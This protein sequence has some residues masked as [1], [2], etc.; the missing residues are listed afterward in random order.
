MPA[1]FQVLP[2]SK[3]IWILWYN[4]NFYSTTLALIPFHQHCILHWKAKEDLLLSRLQGL[5]HLLMY[6]YVT[7]QS[8]AT[9]ACHIFYESDHVVVA[10]CRHNVVYLQIMFDKTADIYVICWCSGEITHT[11]VRSVDKNNTTYPMS[12][13]R[14][15]AWQWIGAKC[16]SSIVDAKC[17]F[18]GLP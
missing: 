1:N 16:G 12:I 6:V 2:C 9:T 3:Q 11:V 17:R 15:S 10:T 4:Q 8:W 14:V 5:T 13:Y 7:T 18:P